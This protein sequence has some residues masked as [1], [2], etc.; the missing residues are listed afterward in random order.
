MKNPD[1][2]VFIKSGIVKTGGKRTEM[3]IMSLTQLDYEA[4]ELLG[5]L[6]YGTE[7]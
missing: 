7:C 4:A 3:D 5:D 6:L 2:M 1:E